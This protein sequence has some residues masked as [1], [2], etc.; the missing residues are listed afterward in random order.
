MRA[1]FMM[2]AVGMLVV[3][4]TAPARA[5][6]PYGVSDED[7]YY[8]NAAHQN[9]LFETTTGTLAETK[10]VCGRVR[11]LGAEFAEHHLRMDADLVAT[12]TRQA[13]VLDAPP[14]PELTGMLTDLATRTSADFDAAWLRDQIAVHRRALADGDWEIRYG[15]SPEVKGVAGASA[16]MLK[17]HLGEARA[18]LTAC[19]TA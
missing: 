19:G 10:G 12:A 16:S 2:L 11:E 3:A 1:L 7:R 15:W 9:N 13:I 5:V 8:A 17:N 18:A 4:P 6:G 14:D